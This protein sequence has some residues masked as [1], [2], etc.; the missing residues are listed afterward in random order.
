[1]NDT[2]WW[3]ELFEALTLV[4]S[5]LDSMGCCTVL[6]GYRYRMEVRYPCKPYNSAIRYIYIYMYVCIITVIMYD[7][8]CACFIP[9]CDVSVTVTVIPLSTRLDRLTSLTFAPSR[10]C[11]IASNPTRHCQIRRTFAYSFPYLCCHSHRQ[12]Q[13]FKTQPQICHLVWSPTAWDPWRSLPAV[14]GDVK[15]NVL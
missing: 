8:R 4:T 11:V 13:P 10:S 9:Y 7:D 2:A 3:I 6:S 14:C 12:C 15:R 5:M 1:M